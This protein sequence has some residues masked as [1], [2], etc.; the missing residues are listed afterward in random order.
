MG[1]PLGLLLAILFNILLEQNILPKLESYSCN[2][3]RYVDDN[4]A[5]VLPK[6]IDLIIHELNSYH[7]NIKFTYELELENKLAFLEVCVN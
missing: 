1:S 2:W 4:L 6:K 5:Y 7:S 3:R